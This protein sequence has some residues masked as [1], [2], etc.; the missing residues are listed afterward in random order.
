MN[1]YRIRKKPEGLIS[2]II[3]FQKIYNFSDFQANFMPGIMGRTPSTWD[4]KLFALRGKVL[5]IVDYAS[6]D[7][8]YELYSLYTLFPLLPAILRFLL[9]KLIWLSPISQSRF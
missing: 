4:K 6:F 2:N 9:I 5:M 7:L 3:L 8:S 1:K